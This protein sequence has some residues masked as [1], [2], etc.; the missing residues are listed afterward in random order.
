MNHAVHKTR[1]LSVSG[2]DGGLANR[3]QFPF[4]IPPELEGC[5]RRDS[6]NSST[7]HVRMAQLSPPFSCSTAPP[8]ASWRLRA[9]SIT[10]ALLHVA[11]RTLHDSGRRIQG[12]PAWTSTPA[13]ASLPLNAAAT[14]PR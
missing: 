2:G 4:M 9:L 5:S 6:R 1:I 11:L 3:G 14:K 13:L 10:R 7:A 8:M 12:S